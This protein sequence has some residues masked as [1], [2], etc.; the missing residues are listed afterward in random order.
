MT[1]TPLRVTAAINVVVHAAGLALAATE[2]RKGT[3]LAGW[4]RMPWLAGDPFAW[5]LGWVVWMA[6]AIALV[7]FVFAAA[8]ASDA[9]PRTARWIVLLAVV[10]AG[11]DMVCDAL[12]IVWIPGLAAED[13]ALFVTVERALGA[14]GQIGANGLYSIAVLMCAMQFERW[15]IRLPGMGTFA[16]GMAM[17]AAGIVG[18]ADLLAIATGPTIGLFCAWSIAVAVWPG[19]PG[20][21]RAPGDP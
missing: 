10:G 14:L 12:W 5:T 8:R 1:A 7:A 13:P 3:P 2:M 15:I 6:C 4:E 18:S 19:P 16:A 9:P 17:V 21:A 20:P 11:I